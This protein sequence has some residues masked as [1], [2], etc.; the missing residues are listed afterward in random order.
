MSFKT[1]KYVNIKFKLYIQKVVPKYFVNMSVH[2][3]SIIIYF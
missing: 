1:V 3:L 2:N